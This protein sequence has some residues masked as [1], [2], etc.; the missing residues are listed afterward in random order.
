MKFDFPIIQTD[1]TQLLFFR[2]ITIT[3]I[4]LDFENQ[5]NCN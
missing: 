1:D 2:P 4:F 5:F 3:I